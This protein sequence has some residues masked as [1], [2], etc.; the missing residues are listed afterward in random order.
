LALLARTGDGNRNNQLNKSAKALGELVGAGVL[1]RGAVEAGLLGAALAIG[2]GDKEARDTIR[3]G[4]EAGIKAPRQLPEKS[5]RGGQPR[6]EGRKRGGGTPGGPDEG[7]PKR[8]WHVG[9]CYFE[10]RRRL[11]LETYDRQGMPQTRPLANFSARIEEEISRDDGLQVRKEFRVNGILESGRLLPPAQIQA[12]EFDSLVWVR[13]EWGAAAALA[14][15]RTLGPHLANAIL[16]HSQDSG[17]RHR[18]VYA[19]AGWR[20]INGH[21]RYLHGGGG[22]GQGEEVEVELGENLG[23]YRL[24][25]PGGPEAAAASLRFLDIG[26][27]E[28]TM[29]LLAAVYLAPFA[30]L[31]QLDFSLWLYGPTGSKKSTIAALALSHYGAFDR[32]NLPGSWFSTVNSLEKLCFTL[33]D[34]LVVIDD[35]MPASSLKDAHKMAEKAGRLIYQ[36]GNRSSRGRLTSD[37][38]ARVN[39]Y[40]R[41]LILSTGE[42]LLPGQRQSATARYLGIELDPQKTPVDTEK[43]TAAQKEADLYSGAMAAFLARIAPRLEDTK[44]EMTELWECYRSAFRN[45][46]HPRMPEIQ[47]WLTVGLEMMLKYQQEVGGLSPRLANELLNRAWKI[48]EALGEKHSRIIEGEKPTL[49]F[50]AILRELLF[51]GRVYAESDGIAG[52]SPPDKESL[53]WHGYEPVHN[54]FKVGWANDEYIYLLPETAYRV[55]SE[56][57]RAQGSYLSLGQNDMFKALSREELIKPGKDRPTRVVRIQGG[58]KRVICLP[59]RNL[60]PP[61]SEDEPNVTNVTQHNQLLVM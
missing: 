9:H 2:L 23:N 47:A 41:G 31:L 33:K 34:T 1:D 38:T 26:P 36:A 4:L 54:A 42:M 7:E 48:F 51:T 10:E 55:I 37:L 17:V 19:H 11:C 29:P 5:G 53:G 46:G 16:A 20:Q 30:E 21:W 56:A 50:L 35:Y 52:G 15:G 25:N 44:R 59:L 24:P 22:L 13:R 8:L 58:N 27:W 18:V 60:S 32:R 43:L 28:V 12:K 14:P 3:S 61:E 40:P 57:V 49:K 39:H 45:A 6:Q